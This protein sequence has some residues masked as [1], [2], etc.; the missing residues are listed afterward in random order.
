[1]SFWI[2]PVDDVYP[3]V[4]R[5]AALAA[6]DPYDPQYNTLAARS[7][8]ISAAFRWIF[9]APQR[10]IARAGLTPL[11]AFME[12]PTA[13]VGDTDGLV[14]ETISTD[15]GHPICIDI[16]SKIMPASDHALDMLAIWGACCT[17]AGDIGT[18]GDIDAIEHIIAVARDMD[19][20]DNN[21]VTRFFGD[22]LDVLLASEEG[23]ECL[24]ARAMAVFVA[25]DA[26]LSNTIRALTTLDVLWTRRAWIS[27]E[28]FSFWA[29]APM[30]I[31]FIF[32]V[33]LNWRDSDARD[34]ITA[35]SRRGRSD[36]GPSLPRPRSMQSMVLA[37]QHAMGYIVA[38]T[39]L[40]DASII[41]IADQPWAADDVL[42]SRVSSAIARRRRQHQRRTDGAAGGAAPYYTVAPTIDIPTATFYNMA[43][44]LFAYTI[45]PPHGVLYATFANNLCD[46][47][48]VSHLEALSRYNNKTIL[49]IAR[50]PGGLYMPVPPESPG[51]HTPTFSG[52]SVVG[53]VVLLDALYCFADFVYWHEYIVW[54]GRAW[55]HGALGS[56]TPKIV[57][58][59]PGWAVV[60]N[61]TLYLPAGVPL[62]TPDPIASEYGHGFFGAY[63]QWC[64]LFLANSAAIVSA[65]LA[66]H[67]AGA[68]AFA[69]DVAEFARALHAL[70]ADVTGY[71]CTPRS[72]IA[73]FDC[74]VS[75]SWRDQMISDLITSI[76][77][78][79]MS[80]VNIDLLLATCRVLRILADDDDQCDGDSSDDEE[81]HSLERGAM[82]S[83][84]RRQ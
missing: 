72:R 44:Q 14:P 75:D 48:T 9:T 71:A 58:L 27:K 43:R 76:V 42:A 80:S 13:F 2:N 62:G 22:W 83:Q 67:D 12:D 29:H 78:D 38:T 52:F 82:P 73:A 47:T 56:G 39:A 40:V 59:G 81:S 18:A 37:M 23:A 64:R 32:G 54:E 7:M 8:M 36:R 57:Q 55:E 34:G 45:L 65:A 11:R 68:Q 10:F 17:A 1:M 53:G 77:G 16:I 50:A 6:H 46:M 30:V 70:L 69:P 31:L 35:R 24:D 5:V 20:G 19:D 3:D 79:A 61:G 51:G 41:R 33:S 84:Q 26:S 25:N 15:G 63:L 49:H 28:T 66:Q 4:C 21:G 60:E 74:L